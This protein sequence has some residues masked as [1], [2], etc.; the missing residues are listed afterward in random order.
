MKR[1]LLIALFTFAAVC[2]G[3]IAYAQVEATT[4]DVTVNIN[5]TDAISITLGPDPIVDFN[6]VDA[7]DYSQE[8]I[9]NKPNHFTVISNQEYNLSVQ[10]TTEFTPTGPALDIVTVSVDPA[11][12]TANGGTAIENVPLNLSPEPL[13]NTANPST[14]AVYQINYE[15][16]DPTPLLGLA[17]GTYTATVTYTATQL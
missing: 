8:Q 4:S 11:S 13:L 6:Y 1:N 9:V 16:A 14:S 10:A 12:V 5:L 3:Q 17:A 15:I 7:D 2:F